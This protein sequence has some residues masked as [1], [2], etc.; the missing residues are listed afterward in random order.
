[1][2]RY[3]TIQRLAVIEALELELGPGFSVLT[4]ETGTGKSI[5]VEAVDLLLGGRASADLVRTG[6]DGAQVQA[7]LEDAA[8]RELLVRREISAAGRSRAFLDGVLV[9]T[10]QLREAVGP[11]VDLHGQHHH[12][13][14]L[15]PEHHLDLLD[16]YAGLQA[17]V[18][19][20]GQAFAAFQQATRALEGT[21]LDERERA[22]RS[23]LLS[24]QLGEIDRLAPRPGEDDELAAERAML[25]SAERLQQQA[26][27]AYFRLYE[28]DR[29]ILGELDQVWRRLGELASLDPRVEPYL[30][31][32]DT[33]KPQLEDVSLFLRSYIAGLETSP[34]RLQH[35]EDR[36]ASLERL[37]RRY[38]PSLDDVIARHQQLRAELAALNVTEARLSELQQDAQAALEA[39]RAAASDLSARRRDTA[40][41]LSRALESE[42]SELAMKG[43]RCEIR[44]QPQC[45]PERGSARGIDAAEFYLS[46]NPGEAPR[47]L[48]RIASGGEL[49]RIMLALKTLATPDAP[50]KTLVFDE[51]DAGIGGQAADMVGKRL[52]RLGE[53]FQVLCITHLP[54]VAAHARTHF[55][56]VKNVEAART[57]TRVTR[58]DDETRAEELARM[59]AGADASARVLAGAREMIAA[60]AGGEDLAKGESERAKAKGRRSGQQI[61]D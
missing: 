20:V 58:L 17:P 1:M 25:G 43:A 33:F 34:E 49:S 37:K 59:I 4:G 42:L 44:F 26:A 38:G 24:F 30:A 54:Q 53:R 50:G 28:A 51:V 55:R 32:R 13:A 61:L 56:V 39:Y 15:E 21:L 48:A 27:D 3:L 6:A 57:H 10:A 19:A 18:A 35:V 14:L 11:L 7:V 12:Q 22:A 31:L 60:R 5:V 16:H 46:A 41:R 2:L 23:D 45:P 52:R 29:S 47:P 8:G 9:T 36:L 40:S